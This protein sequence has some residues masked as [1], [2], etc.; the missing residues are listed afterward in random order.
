[1]SR[2]QPYLGLLGSDSRGQEDLKIL[3]HA[4]SE[5]ATIDSAFAQRTA[6]AAGSPA[7]F[8][9]NLRGNSTYNNVHPKFLALVVKALLNVEDGDEAATAGASVGTRD[10]REAKDIVLALL[11]PHQ[12]VQMKLEIKQTI[13]P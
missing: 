2:F 7:N 1:M 10:Q 6:A 13:K 11:D 8:N 9:D 12:E 5:T 4:L 3:L